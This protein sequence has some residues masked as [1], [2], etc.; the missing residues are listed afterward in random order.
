[1]EQMT[2][3]ETLERRMLRRAAAEGRPVTGT[4]E[5]TP[6]C[7]M[8]CDMCYIRL[9]RE[10]AE[11][12]GGLRTAEEWLHLGREMAE[13]GVLFLLLTGGE[14]LLFPGF[15]ELYAGLRRMGFILTVNTNGTLLDEDWADFFA[16]NRPRR[17]NITL[18]GADGAA[19]ETL[20][21]HPGG[22]DSAV[23]AIRLLRARGVDVKINGSVTRRNLDDM[24]AIYALGRELGAPVH[25]DTYMLPGLHERE[26]PLQVQSRLSPEDAALA[27][28]RMIREERGGEALRSLAATARALQ[29]GH[30]PD[31]LVCMAGHCSFA[32]DWRG[33]MRPCVTLSE[34]AAPVFEAGFETAWKQIT[35]QAQRLCVAQSCLECALRPL[36][37]TCA[38]SAK[39][40]TG[41]YD[42]VPAYLCSM[43]R[44]LAAKLERIA[45]GERDG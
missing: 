31:G 28:L 36:C 14:P 30:Y 13:A 21:H 2:E 45:Q 11:R 34:P 42:G 27:E 22:F 25:M 7:N 44:A 38:A 33:S 19:Y 23:R 6:L 29:P 5:L 3:R 18:Y 26:L 39:L 8:R 17:V 41:R 37:K 20:C 12:L 16:Q 35:A 24:G 32:V 4:L 43:T 10:E 40:E 1:M 9:E 15:R